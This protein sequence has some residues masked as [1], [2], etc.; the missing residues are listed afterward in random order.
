MAESTCIGTST[1]DDD[2]V[3][4]LTSPDISPTPR[5]SE[6]GIALGVPVYRGVESR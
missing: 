1:A 5:E 6:D 2:D 4:L 3:A